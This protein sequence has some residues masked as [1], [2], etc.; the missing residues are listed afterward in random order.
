MPIADAIRE[1]QSKS[2]WIRRMFEEGAQLKKRYGADK[3]FDFSIG[4]PDVEPPAA[5]HET[6][7]RLATEDARGTHGYMANAGYPAVREALARKA[8][9]DHGVTIDGS[10]VVM[11]VGAAGGLNT[12]L[13]AIL[14][15]G[16]EVV[17][18]RPYFVE[19]G[20]YIANHGGRM[21]LVDS[22]DDFDLDVAAIA[23]A[24]SPRTAAF[25][26]NSPNNPTGRVYPASTIAALADA[27]RAHGKACGR[28]PYIIADEPY[29]EI[30]YNGI[31]VPPVLSAY[32]ESIVVT[33][34]SKSLSLPGERIGYIAVGPEAAEPEELMGALAFSTRV[35]GFVNAPALMQRV[36]SELTEARVDVGIYAHRRDAFKSVLDG[37]RIEYAEPEG[38]FYLF[39]KVPPKGSDGSRDDV[40]FT[41]ALKDKLVLAVPGSGF[42]APGWF[43]LSYCIDEKTI[44][45]SRPAFKAAADGWRSA[46]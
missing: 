16:D 3:V 20:A 29:R 32:E 28:R 8:S 43:R 7:V 44:E 38:A 42:G 35:L 22:K 13:K 45:A 46:R 14:N 39:C 5:F 18:S 31:T 36:V 34:Y 17:V 37:A 2:S 21:V 10:R 40:A 4:N 6:L 33:S 15:P 9:S 19:Y 11:A 26:L 1:A 24:M 27:L 41:M 23:A 12:V 25:L 30:V